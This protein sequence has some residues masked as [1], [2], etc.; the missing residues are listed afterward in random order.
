MR[1]LGT[2]LLTGL[3]LG[4]GAA[5][6]APADKATLTEV[7]QSLNKLL[8]DL[9]KMK[10]ANT[11]NPDPSSRKRMA[12]SID[13]ALARVRAAMAGKQRGAMKKRA[14]KALVKALGK[15]P[16]PKKRI[17]LLRVKIGLDLVRA[18]QAIKLVKGFRAEEGR[19]AAA[20]LLWPQLVDVK[21]RPALQRAVGGKAAQARLQQKLKFK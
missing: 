14:F 5:H 10:Q 17:A 2:L 9:L 18:D 19:I 7:K 20:A 13:R 6:G 16:D 15:E 21:Q 12:A 3:L 1:I 11:K 8:G 4:H